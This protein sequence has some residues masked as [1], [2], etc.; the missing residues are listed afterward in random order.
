ISRLDKTVV[1]G[2]SLSYA[3]P[4]YWS[5]LMGLQSLSVVL[6]WSP[7][8]GMETVRAGSTGWARAA[9]IA[10]HS[11]SPTVTSGCFFMAVYVRSTRASMSEVIGMDFVK[12]ARA[13]GV[14]PSRVIRAHV[15]RNA[16]SP[17]ITFAGIQSGQMAGGAVSTETVF[18]WPGI[19]RSMF[20]ASSQ[21]DYQSSSGIFSVTSIRVVVCNS[22]TDVSYRSIDPRIGA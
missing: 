22:L 18:A 15:S 8:F 5:S 10:Q 17:V 19:G 9:D 11:I 1:P 6:G 12:T 7:A 3:A 14:S 2:A 21:R 20:D 16:S 13:K 4:Q